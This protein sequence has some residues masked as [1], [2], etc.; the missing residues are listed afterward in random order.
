ME[1]YEDILINGNN[2]CNNMIN[3][4]IRAD[5][6]YFINKKNIRWIRKMD[7][8]LYICSKQ[9]G[10]RKWDTHQIC[11]SNNPKSYD[12]LNKLLNECHE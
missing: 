1:Y 3:S 4:F 6:N 10:C 2:K 11:K 8:C 7:E 5:D 9:A 12:K